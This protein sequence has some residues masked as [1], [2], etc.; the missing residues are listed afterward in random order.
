[1]PDWKKINPPKTFTDEELLHKGRQNVAIRRVKQAK[2]NGTLVPATHCEVC[3]DPCTTVAHHYKGYSHPF[4]VWWVC[5]FCNA[6]IP[7][8]DGSWTVK[9]ARSHVLYKKF[10][11]PLQIASAN[12]HRIRECTVCGIDFSAYTGT[13][14][15]GE[16][17]FLC[18]YCSQNISPNG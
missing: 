15:F 6:N 14:D 12:E 3:G 7:V 13:V 16:N 17:L 1:M 2:D 10:E 9:D 4:S 5:R 11:R 18:A 8:H